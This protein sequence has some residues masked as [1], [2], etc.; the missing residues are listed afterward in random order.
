LSGQTVPLNYG[1]AKRVV[2]QFKERA[3]RRTFFRE[4][5]KFRGLTLEAAADRAGMT[6]GN[7]SAMER[8]AQGY[9]QSG[10]EALADAYQCDPGQLLTVDPTQGDGIWSIWERAKPG[11]RQ[12]IAD[13]AR[14]IVGKTGT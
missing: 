6:A 12:K 2:P 3:R 10:L 1:M 8:G 7:L 4:W 5:R 13:I 9:T 14:T 11:D